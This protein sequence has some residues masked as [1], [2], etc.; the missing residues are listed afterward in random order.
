MTLDVGD[1][2]SA[3]TT[4]I[5]V[6]HWLTTP[7]IGAIM[8]ALTS[9]GTSILS[10]EMIELLRVVN[11]VL[12]DSGVADMLEIAVWLGEY[13]RV[14]SITLTP[15]ISVEYAYSARTSF[16]GTTGPRNLIG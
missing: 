1:R 16:G 12:R 4:G 10:P 7:R 2:L 11:E 13:W 14:G 3:R 5:W 9:D 6:D 8:L 15:F